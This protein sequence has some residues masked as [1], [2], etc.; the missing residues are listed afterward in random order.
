MC[1]RGRRAL[2]NQISRARLGPI[3]GFEWRQVVQSA[4][5]TSRTS[6]LGK[7]VK[8]DRN[9]RLRTGGAVAY[10]KYLLPVCKVHT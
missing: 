9:L 1:A 7:Q 5:R 6:S 10:D 8:V 3:V 4:P 2:A